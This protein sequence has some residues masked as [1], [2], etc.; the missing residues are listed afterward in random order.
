LLFFKNGKEHARVEGANVGAIEA[1]IREIASGAGDG[2]SMT[3]QGQKL[4]SATDD[5]SASGAG[6]SPTFLQAAQLQQGWQNY[7]TVII[8]GLFILY[9]WWKK[10]VDEAPANAK[11]SH[12]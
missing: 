5:G 11:F 6:A 1:R 2:G 3:G 4:G 12:D 10:Q 8:V 9:L 7:T